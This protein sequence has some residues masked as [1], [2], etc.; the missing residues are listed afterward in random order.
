MKMPT[1]ADKKMT[2]QLFTVEGSLLM[3]K[4]LAVGL[5]AASAQAHGGGASVV[6]KS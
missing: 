5:F 3:L 4:T 1:G 2:L 6:L